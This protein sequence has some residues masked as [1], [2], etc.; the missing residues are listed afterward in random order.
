[1][2]IVERTSRSPHWPARLRIAVSAVALTSGIVLN[3]TICV[4]QSTNPP[5]V[6]ASPPSVIP[7]G[8]AL[9]MVSP[10]VFELGK[11]RLEKK[12]RTV[13]FPAFL[14]MNQGPLEY[15]LVT[16]YGKK[17][18]SLLSTEVEPLQIHV[19][20]L[21]LG[22]K[23]SDTNQLSTAPPSQIKSP[24]EKVISGDPVSVEISWMV[25]G[26]EVR[27]PARELLINL[28]NKG[29]T[30]KAPWV[31]NGSSVWD[32]KFLAQRD[33]S[34]VSLVNDLTALVNNT[35]QGHD[36]D[37]VWIPATNG[38]PSLNTPVSVTIRL[39]EARDHK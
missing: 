38:L 25:L 11:V 6:A 2:T 5:P 28:E 33:G 3:G 7:S 14:N 4:A 31:Y 12:Q 26:K 1:M 20:M 35:G 30:E 21:L 17:H 16:S 10:G 18:E 39:L 15:L 23:A 29:T 24:S 13:S 19:A 36:N 37:N 32:G 34:I 27:F 22:I 8:L 9:K